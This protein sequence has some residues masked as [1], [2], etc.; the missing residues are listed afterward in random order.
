[1]NLSFLNRQLESLVNLANYRQLVTFP[2]LLL[3]LLL[4]RLACHFL[5][6]IKHKKTSLLKRDEV[7][8]AVPPLLIQHGTVSNLML[9]MD[10]CPETRLSVSSRVNHNNSIDRNSFSQAISFLFQSTFFVILFYH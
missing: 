1:S 5:L 2:L 3:Q 10:Y 9:I 6:K 7:I 8:F 4:V